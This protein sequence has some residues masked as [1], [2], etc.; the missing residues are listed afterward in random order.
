MMKT[1]CKKAPATLRSPGPDLCATEVQGPDQVRAIL[2][3]IAS[4]PEESGTARVSACRLLLMEAR[5]CDDG[6]EAH[7]DADLNKRALALM[8]KSVELT[9][10]LPIT[11]TH[12]GIGIYAGQPAKRVALVKAEIDRVSGSPTR[13][14]FPRLPPTARG[15]LSRD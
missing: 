1:S 7:R 11:T 6:R 3:G 9:D 4:N 12:R 2:W 10:D 5:E 14:S 13:S 8:R 15:H